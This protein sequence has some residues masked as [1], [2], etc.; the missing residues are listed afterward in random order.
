MK[1][2]CY[3]PPFQDTRWREPVTK[4]VAAA[5]A[6]T[7]RRPPRAGCWRSRSFP[8]TRRWRAVK[9]QSRSRAILGAWEDHRGRKSR[10]RS[11]LALR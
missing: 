7:T 1:D 6:E 9:S 8:M 3:Q 11:V 2:F 4:I 5:V 10:R